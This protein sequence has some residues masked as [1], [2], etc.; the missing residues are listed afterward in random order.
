MEYQLARAYVAL[1]LMDNALDQLESLLRGTDFVSR[2]W[3]RVDPDFAPLRGDPRF[4][5]LTAQAP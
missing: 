2:G 1:G 5:R 4:E 3:L